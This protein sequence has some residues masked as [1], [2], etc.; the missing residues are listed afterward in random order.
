MLWREDW[1][2]NHKHV[3]RIMREDDLLCP[4]KPLF[5]PPTTD[6]RHGWRVWL[7]LA[8]HLMPMV[9]NQVWVADISSTYVPTITG[10]PISL[11]C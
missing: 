3:V 4:K 8:R 5:M 7:N 9:T 2:V 11:S 10:L 6:A 1:Y